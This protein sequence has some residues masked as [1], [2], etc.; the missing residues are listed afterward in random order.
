[1]YT[2]AIK[3]KSRSGITHMKTSCHTRMQ[4]HTW[5]HHV[6]VRDICQRH[7]YVHTY[8]NVMSRVFTRH[9]VHMNGMSLSTG[10]RGGIQG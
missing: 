1:M 5:K 10:T 3:H 2:P 6:H 8:K 4:T 9:V 7:A